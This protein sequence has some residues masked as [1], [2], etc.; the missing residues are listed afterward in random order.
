LTVKRPPEGEAEFEILGLP[1]G[2]TS[3]TP[4]VKLTED[5]KQLDFPIQMGPDARVGQF[6]TL[7]IKATIK[8][9][10]GTIVQTQGTGELTL[11]PPAP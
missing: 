3:S 10:S 6:K 1:A 8:R 11:T 4:I 9:P 7:V 2:V 5:L